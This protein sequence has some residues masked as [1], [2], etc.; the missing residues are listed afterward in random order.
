MASTVPQRIGRFEIRG[1]LG[2]GAMGVVYEAHDPRLNRE[3]AVK[4]LSRELS[5]DAA[6]LR[7]FE[8][9][10]RAASALNHPN[11]VTV[12]D[13]GTD[14]QIAYLVTERLH[15]S[16]LS[17]RLT[18]KPLPSDEAIGFAIEIAAGLA[19]A[20]A[21]GIVHRDIKPQNIF[22]TRSGTVKLLDFGIAQLSRARV[23]GRE[24]PETTVADTRNGAIVGTP[25]YMAPEQIRGAAVDGRSDLF[26]LGCLLHEML[27][28]TGP[29]ARSTA[30]DA[31]AAV[32]TDT[33]ARPTRLGVPPI[34]ERIV[35]RCLEKLPEDR[36]QS[37]AD[38][39]FA[40]EVAR[41]AGG[42]TPVAATRPR[43]R[44]LAW[45]GLATA[46]LGVSVL[47]AWMV[48]GVRQTTVPP[49][50]SGPAV[51]RVSTVVPASARPVAPAIGP[52]G[53]WVA[54]IG[55]AGASPSLFVQFLNGGP[56][57]SLTEGLDLPLQTRTIVGGIDVLP[58]GSGITVAGRPQP[59]GLWKLPGIWVV[60]APAGGPPRR[61]T[62]RY[63][64]VRWS[65]DG[66]RFAAII[67]NPLIGDAVAVAEAD[68]QN[69]R[70]LVPAGGGVHLHHVAWGHDGRHVYY[71]RTLE[72][73]HNLS[74][75][76]RVDTATGVQEPFVQ[77]TGIAMFPAPTPD[78]RAVI[79]AGDR[80]GEGL[81]LWW[82]PFDGSPEGRLTAGA[83][84]FSEPYVSRDGRHLVALARH[85]RGEIV[86][87]SAG[88][89]TIAVLQDVSGHAGSD[90]DPTVG[91]RTGR[92][93]VTSLRS[94]SR[95]IWSIS[96]SGRGLPLTS[97]PDQDRRPAVSPDEQ[98]VAFVSN[99]NGRRGIWIVPADGGTPR[100]V[101]EVDVIDTLSWA[102][103]GRRLVYATAAEGTL[104]IVDVRDGQRQRVPVGSARVPA[105]S[106]VADAI[107]FVSVVGDQPHVRVVSPNGKPIRDPVAITPVSLPTATAWSP[108]G[109]R[110]AM[111][112]LP[113]RG[114]AEAWILEMATG[115]LRK[116]AEL[117]AP[118]VFEGVSWS[119]DGQ[120][121]VLGRVD[122]DSEVLLMEL[123]PA[124][125][126]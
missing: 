61:L 89:G 118:S 63:G 95:K 71:S 14:G 122:Y 40:L 55:L 23:A 15:G 84:E 35:A 18:G 82:R 111:V 115:Q 41:G 83:G 31:M 30:P 90:L 62:E 119:A 92:V 110:L 96:P 22:V 65:T 36:F 37:A 66:S 38:L 60:P 91:R 49:T 44:V 88:A 48:A 75:I 78:G 93:F 3:V 4:V 79:Y 103:D 123:A 28:G 29:F 6:L 114:A 27:V 112:N 67:A 5:G 20:H 17:E 97:G 101:I 85:Q 34:L 26:A 87:I 10:A 56:P 50:D 106:P 64:S 77:T 109:Q 59:V 94:G 100:P 21:A 117:P 125:A 99:R 57:V 86:S 13:A 102:P 2:A 16:T 70:V 69:E 74:E 76:Y 126:R 121:L 107:A 32:L 52:D 104:E 42:T 47:A 9:E 53:K 45:S 80:T 68:G 54:Y 124:P 19:A 58:D 43:A 105:W 81:N 24:E 120:S 72:P 39:R 108:D 11:I 7:R 25:G 12:F 73:N 51:V 33:P 46:L 116:A 8:K 113:G 98:Q 1:R